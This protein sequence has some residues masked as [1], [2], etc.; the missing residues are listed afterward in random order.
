MNYSCWSWVMDVLT[1]AMVGL[2]RP[3]DLDGC[4]VI[5]ASFE[6][7]SG[8]QLGMQSFMLVPS[9]T[10]WHRVGSSSLQ[11]QEVDEQREPESA[12]NIASLHTQTS[13]PPSP[14][15]NT[16]EPLLLSCLHFLALFLNYDPDT[17]FFSLLRRDLAVNPTQLHIGR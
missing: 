9:N 12:H 16:A 8:K 4:C 2:S 13:Q 5:L 14:F 15:R 3:G 7:K 10:E 1:L 17:P 6:M 11:K